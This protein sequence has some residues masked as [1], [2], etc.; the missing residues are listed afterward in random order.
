MQHVD[1]K[2]R[3]GKRHGRAPWIAAAALLLAGS[4]AAALFLTREPEPDDPEPPVTAGILMNRDAGELESVTV[5]QKGSEPWTLIRGEDGQMH[6]NGEE[7][8]AAESVMTRMLLESLANLAYEAVLTENPADYRGSEAA[9]G[10][11]EPEVTASARFTDGQE[12]TVRIGS[13]MA[14][15]EGWY[16]MTVDGDDRLFAISRG[17]AEDLDISPDHMH[18]VSQP[19]IY[20][21]LL[22][23][24]TLTGADG[25]VT[26]EWQLQG[27]ITDQDASTKWIITVPVRYPADDASIRTLKSC[28]EDLNLG[29]Y[30]EEATE[31]N[32]EKRGLLHPAY[33][34]TLHMAA[35]STGKVS[36]SGVYDVADRPENT[37][38]IDIAESEDG[39][40]HYIRFGNEIDRTGHITLAPFLTTKPLDTAARYLFATPLNSLSSLTVEQDGITTEYTLKRGIPVDE[41]TGETRT[42]CYRNGTE[43]PYQAFEAMYERLLTANITGR[44][45]ADAEIGN[46]HTKYTLRTVSGG[47]HTVTLSD[48]DGMQDAVT[49]DGGTLFYI[50]RNSFSADIPDE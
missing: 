5:T 36:D 39:L 38:V 26:A 4:V 2:T 29:N 28:A 50:S 45:P 12:I 9:F 25:N 7:A 40:L 43:I 42:A 32:L 47:A 33:T 48:W 44:L 20:G 8:W 46:A 14:G 31:E 35:G 18:P 11:E 22:D 17:Q 19:E 1:R 16:Y 23:R 13:Q 30:V 15:E 6:L 37:V 41:D 21:M 10:L 49:I 27:S 34:L 3:K 24:I